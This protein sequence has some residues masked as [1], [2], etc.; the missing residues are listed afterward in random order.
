MRKMFVYAAVGTLLSLGAAPAVM[1]QAV[2]DPAVGG[3]LNQCWGQIASQVA[4]LGGS[5]DISGGGM[6][7]HSRS[8]KA[9]NNVGGFA[10][11]QNGFGITFNVKGVIDPATG[12]PTT[13]AGRQGVGNMSKG[14]PHSTHTGDGGN[15]QHALNNSSDSVN[16]LGLSNLLDGVSGQLTP[17]LGGTGAMNNLTCSLVP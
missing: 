4:K 11:D 1:A 10:S 12:L 16:G 7:S 8:T 5:D 13:N 9:A 3:Q 2:N 17:V 14:A 15:G 6:G